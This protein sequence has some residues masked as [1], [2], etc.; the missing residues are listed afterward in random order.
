MKKIINIILLALVAGV[1]ALGISNF[2]TNTLFFEASLISC[3]SLLAV[4]GFSFF[5][6]QRMTDSRKQRDIMLK[7]AESLLELVS[8]P[9]SYKISN[10][11]I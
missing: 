2:Q 5:F 7:L 10:D 8:C 1:I 4:I 6:V 11:E 3:L 9:D